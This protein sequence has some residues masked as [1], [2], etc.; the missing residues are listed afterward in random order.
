MKRGPLRIIRTSI[1]LSNLDIK[2]IAIRP[3]P[4]PRAWYLIYTKFTYVVYIYK[5]YVVANES[6]FQIRIYN[7]LARP[8]PSREHIAE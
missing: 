3:R 4:Y 5:Y 8:S 1:I 6:Y 7:Q 2:N